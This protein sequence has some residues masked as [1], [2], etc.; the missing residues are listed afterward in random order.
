[1]IKHAVLGCLFL[2]TTGLA[3]IVQAADDRDI[4]EF[5]DITGFDVALESI[6]LSADTVPE[7]LGFEAEDFGS[8]W[9][10]LVDEV[11]ET[12]LMLDMARTILGQALDDE[13]REHAVAFYASDLGKRLVEVENR[14]HMSE[15]DALKSESG[16]QIIDGLTRINS[17]RVDILCRMNDASDV[18]GHSLRAVQELQIRFLMAATV[19]GIIELQMDEADLREAFRSQEDELRATMKQGALENA[20]YTYQAFS[21]DEMSQYADALAHPEMQTVY[22]LMNAIQFEIMANRFEAIALRMAHMRPSQD[23]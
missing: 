22:A 11:F 15:D 6:R 17:P 18:G 23:L 13:L 12:E 5:L 7:M 19:A 16:A 4:D 8:E 2:L 14:S 9:S 20:A 10:R 1:M 21:D 3:Q